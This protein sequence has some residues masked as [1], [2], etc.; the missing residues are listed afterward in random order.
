MCIY[1]YLTINHPICSLHWQFNYPQYPC[2]VD[3]KRNGIKNHLIR[4]SI[5]QDSAVPQAP[6]VRGLLDLAGST[7]TKTWITENISLWPVITRHAQRQQCLCHRRLP[8]ITTSLN[9][10]TCFRQL[11]LCWGRD[12]TTTLSNTK[13]FWSCKKLICGKTKPTL[14]TMLYRA[15]LWIFT[16]F[17]GNNAKNNVLVEVL[18]LGGGVWPLLGAILKANACKPRQK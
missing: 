11:R 6:T 18:G 17:P 1:S 12:R 15:C 4:E 10:E 7:P 9:R 5:M 8:E 14:N 3:R 16:D 13:S 2:P